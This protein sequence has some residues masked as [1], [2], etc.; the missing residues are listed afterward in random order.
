MGERERLMSKGIGGSGAGF[1][2]RSEGRL[3]QR[4]AFPAAP[5]PKDARLAALK[6]AEVRARQHAVMGGG[7]ALG[8][9]RTSLEPTEA[10]RRAAETRAAELKRWRGETGE[11]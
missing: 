2:A 5:P 9:A 4:G 10:A 11:S 8:G 7:G 1:D 6:A 3:G